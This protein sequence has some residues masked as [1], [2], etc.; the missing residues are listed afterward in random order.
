MRFFIP[1]VRQPLISGSSGEGEGR[2]RFSA[3]KTA[4]RFIE[5]CRTSERFANIVAS[6]PSLRSFNLPWKNMCH[7]WLSNV[8]SPSLPTSPT[9][10]L[11]DSWNQSWS[12]LPRVVAT[13]VARSMRR[14][15]STDRVPVGI[16]FG[17]SASEFEALILEIFGRK[18]ICSRAW[19]TFRIEAFLYGNDVW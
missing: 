17:G 5:R 4:F 8:S 13:L 12:R 11:P 2:E 7:L 1:A 6:A 16:D 18:E 14:R 9:I 19:R 10:H 3:G 15:R